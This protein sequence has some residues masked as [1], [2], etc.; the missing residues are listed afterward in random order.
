MP[1]RSTQ[2][3]SE[4]RPAMCLLQTALSQSPKTCRT[5][6]ISHS[7]LSL[8]HTH[9][10]TLPLSLCT[11]SFYLFAYPSLQRVTRIKIGATS[12]RFSRSPAGRTVEQRC[13]GAGRRLRFRTLRVSTRRASGCPP[14]LPPSVS[15][16][17]SSVSSCFIST[18][19]LAHPSSPPQH[20]AFLS[21]HAPPHPLPQRL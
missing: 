17:T 9:T 14:P 3:C 11:C 13:A 15:V 6:Q 16:F 18:R 12:P 20:P 5:L 8:S 4:P 19:L 1:L 7:S 21:G 2:L 10:L